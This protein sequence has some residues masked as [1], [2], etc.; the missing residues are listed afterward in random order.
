MSWTDQVKQDYIIQTGDGVRYYPDWIN[1]TKSLEF[2]VSEF[3]F[4]ELEGTK[5]DRRKIRGRKFDIEIYFQGE[6]H[7]DESEAFDIS[8]RD[9]RAWNITHPFYGK[10]LVQPT[11]LNFDNTKYNVTKITG[12]VIE[13]L[14]DD[15]PKSTFDPADNIQFKKRYADST[16]ANNF[17][18]KIR[19]NSHDITRISKNNTKI[20]NEGAKFARLKE[21]QNYFN[22]FQSANSKIINATVDPLAAI[23]EVQAMINYPGLFTDSVTNRLTVLGNQFSILKTSISNFSI[24]LPNEKLIYENQA[25]GIVS[26]MAQTAAIPQDGDYKSRSEVISAIEIVLNT[27]NSYLSDLDNLQTDNGGDTDSYIPDYDSLSVLNDLVNYSV[28]N[29][30]NIALNSKQ[31]RSIIIEEDTNIIL[32]THR[33][34]GLDDADANMQQMIETNNIGLNELLGIRKGRKILY[35]V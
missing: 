1:A 32:L 24:V 23:T 12:T 30:F 9:Q 26:T 3:D 20:Y 31:E 35:Y 6:D 13:T 21:A 14:S 33:F 18:S 22:L 15:N 28:T 4:P 8:A 19:F 25:G 16:Y 11:V 10:L 2:N 34:Y 7:L 27:Y 5:V 17:S 29:L